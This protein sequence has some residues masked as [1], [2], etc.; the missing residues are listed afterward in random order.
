[1]YV[2]MIDGWKEATVELVQKFADAL[3][4]TAYEARQKMIGG[5]PVVVASYADVQQAQTLVTKLNQKGLSALV[6]DALAFRSQ[7]GHLV[8]RRFELGERSLSIESVDGKIAE[9]PYKEIDLLLPATCTIEYSETKT[10]VE[11]K[12]S[13]GKTLL[14][15]GVPM[16][17][18]VER[19]EVVRTEESNRILYLYAGRRPPVDLRQDGMTYDGFGAFMKHSR[20]LNFSYLISELRRLSPEA[21]FD[22]RLLNRAGQVRLLGFMLKPETNLNLAADILSLSLR[23]G[24]SQRQGL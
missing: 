1:M 7:S 13:I 3:G 14:A 8:A 24:G 19:Q 21:I 2:L 20:E 4:I 17:N 11:R 12:F 10:V 5:G 6:I 15:G 16:S 9:I 22:D 23:R 18:K